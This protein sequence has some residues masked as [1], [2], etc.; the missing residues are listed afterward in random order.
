[1][2]HFQVIFLRHN[3]NEMTEEHYRLLAVLEQKLNDLMAFCT[4]QKT[5]LDALNR[6]LERKTAETEQLQAAFQTLKANY[7]NL[8]AAHVLT[9]GESGSVRDVQK[10]LKKLVREI[11]DCINYVTQL[12]G[13]S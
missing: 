1:M 2:F 10:K 7:E 3:W 4:R 12:N 5:G 13:Q 9:S 8:L 11:D 6:A